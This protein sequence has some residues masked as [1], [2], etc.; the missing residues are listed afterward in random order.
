[1][2]ECITVDVFAELRW[3]LE[4]RENGGPVRDCMSFSVYLT[5][6]EKQC[7]V[8]N[9]FTRLCWD[10]LLLMAPTAVVASRENFI[11]PRTVEITLVEVVA[12]FCGQLQ[13]REGRWGRVIDNLHDG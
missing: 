9:G 5:I 2:A 12:Y 8:G 10:D 6:C 7:P 3:K 4:E 1:M 11:E 13:E